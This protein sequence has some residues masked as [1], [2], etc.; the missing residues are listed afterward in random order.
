[1]VYLSTDVADL[2]DGHDGAKYVLTGPESITHAELVGIIG[3]AIGEEVRCQDAARDRARPVDSRLG[4]RGVRG[5]PTECVADVRGGTVAR[6][7][8]HCR[9]LRTQGPAIDRITRN[10]PSAAQDAEGPFTRLLLRP[11]KPP[12]AER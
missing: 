1:V 6:A 4:Q 2:A 7:S 9:A 10:G 8:P 12:F 5:C 11:V 3:E